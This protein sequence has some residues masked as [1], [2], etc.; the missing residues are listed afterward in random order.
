MDSIVVSVHTKLLQHQRNSIAE[1]FEID[2]SIDLLV[3]ERFEVFLAG[4]Q[5]FLQEITFQAPISQYSIAQTKNNNN[6]CQ[7]NNMR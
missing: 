7:F 6:Y 4:T 1:V 3:V 2:S 5:A